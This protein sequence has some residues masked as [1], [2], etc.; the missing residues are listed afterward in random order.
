MANLTINGKTFTL[1]VEPDT[2]LLW[3]IREN[4]GL[5]GTKYG[6]GIAQCGACTVHMDGV[7]TRSCGISV[8]EAEGKKITTI[9]GLASGDTLHKVQAAWIAKDV[10]QCGYCQSGMIMAVAAL[11]A[12]KPKPTDA[13]ID[14]AITNICRCGTFQQVREAIHTIASA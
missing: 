9:E 14:E 11:L 1:D 10:P 8:S 2:P 5:T 7:A 6:C 13:D 12:E 3:A 4:A